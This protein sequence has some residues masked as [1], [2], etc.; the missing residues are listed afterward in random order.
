[1][2]SE[3]MLGIVSQAKK[4]ALEQI[5]K[6]KAKG[7]PSDACEH[8]TASL[9]CMFDAVEAQAQ[10]LGNGLTSAIEHAICVTIKTEL[11]RRPPAQPSTFL[12]LG[13]SFEM[14]SKSAVAVVVC[15]AIGCVTWF[16]IKYAESKKPEQINHAELLML[17]D[18][19]I[20]T[21]DS[22]LATAKQEAVQQVKAAQEKK[23]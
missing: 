3:K 21:W 20:S 8:H 14:G 23:R 6:A 2:T 9:E 17:K 16:G 11:A 18:E 12:R 7:L 10:F 15:F 5:A 22:K 1:M 4:T 19:L 13:K